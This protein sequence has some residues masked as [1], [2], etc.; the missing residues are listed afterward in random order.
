MSL[1]YVNRKSTFFFYYSQSSYKNVD[2][3]KQQGRSISYIC[4]LITFFLK[5]KKNYKKG[6]R[7]LSSRGCDNLINLTP[8]F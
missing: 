6:A 5:R 7:D 3:I 8:K 4:K 1:K 2:L